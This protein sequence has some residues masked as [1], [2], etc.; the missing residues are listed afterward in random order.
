MLSLMLFFSYIKG[1]PESIKHQNFDFSDGED[2][3]DDLRGT[4]EDCK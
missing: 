1:L 2:E 3:A 4:A